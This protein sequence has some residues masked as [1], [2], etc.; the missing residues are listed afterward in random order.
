MKR[1]Y[2][3]IV[4]VGLVIAG[5]TGCSQSSDTTTPPAST[6]APAAK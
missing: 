2:T 3:L 6:N 1:I 5:V 4:L